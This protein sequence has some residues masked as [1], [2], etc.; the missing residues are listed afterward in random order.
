[1]ADDQRKRRAFGLWIVG[2]VRDHAEEIQLAHASDIT[3][4]ADRVIQKLAEECDADAE[5]ESDGEGKTH[6]HGELREARR[7]RGFRLTGPLQ[8]AERLG[9]FVALAD[10]IEAAAHLL[11]KLA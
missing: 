4:R 8:A 2:F 3:R 9:L 10:R 1:M 7:I 5:R 6:G 11:E